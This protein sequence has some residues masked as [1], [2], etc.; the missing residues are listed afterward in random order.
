VRALARP[1]DVVI[2]ISASGRSENVLR[3]VAAARALGVT[4]VRT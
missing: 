4:T 2:A 3:A 1:G